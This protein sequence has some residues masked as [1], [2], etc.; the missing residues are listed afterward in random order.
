MWEARAAMPFTSEA[1][2]CALM[3][4]TGPACSNFVYCAEGDTGTHFA[5]Y[6]IDTD[7][8]NSALPNTPNATD[9]YGS[10]SGAFNGNFYLVGGTT[11]LQQ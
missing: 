7:T 4:A 9:D 2:T 5:S 6:N 10:A 8:W 1:P 3:P 11:G